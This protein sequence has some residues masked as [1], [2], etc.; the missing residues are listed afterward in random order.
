MLHVYIH[1]HLYI[2]YV[3]ATTCG[4]ITSLDTCMTRYHRWGGRCILMMRFLLAAAKVSVDDITIDKIE[5]ITSGVYPSPPT[6]PT[7]GRVRF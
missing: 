3:P 7:H 4:C 2:H 5:T 6:R 1:T